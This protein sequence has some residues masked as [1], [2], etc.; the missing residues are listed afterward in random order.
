VKPERKISPYGSWLSP[1]SADLIAEDSLSLGQIVLDGRDVYWSEMR[2]AD[3]GRN[4]IMRWRQG[5]LEEILPAPF[6]AR[7]RVNEYGG[8]AFTV[9][10]RVVYFSHDEDQHLYR[11]R[12]GHPPHPLTSE[13]GRRYADGAFDHRFK[14]IICV[15][16]D[17]R[18]TGEPVTTIVEVDGSGMGKARVLVS[19]HDFYAAPKISTD[20]LRM[21]WLAWNHP[22]MPWDG[23]ELWLAD[24]A[25]DGSLINRRLVAGGREESIFQPAFSPG[26]KLY[27]VS[28][29]SHW[30]NLYRV[31]EEGIEAMSP[32]DAEFGLPQWVFGM[33]TYAIESESR[34]V[35]SFNR[36]GAWQLATLDLETHQLNFIETPFTDIHGLVVGH[37]QAVFVAASPTLLPAVVRMDLATSRCE[38]LRTSS[39][40][41]IKSGYLSIP[42]SLSFPT[43]NGLKTYAFYYPPEN[44]DFQA[45]T[46]GKPPLLVMGHGGPTS[47][48]S[49][50][51]S[52]KIQYWTSRG[53]AVLDVN[54]RGSTGYGRD[55]RNQLDGLWG[56]A[57]VEDCVAGARHL[58]K[59]GLVDEKRLGIRGG[60]AG[61]YTTLCALASHACFRAAA[62]YYGVS[63]LEALARDTH[64]FESHYLNRLIGPY[65]A[66]RDLYQKRS[67]VNHANHMSCPVIFFQGLEDKVVPPDQT[68]KMVNDL[69][70]RGIPLA[71]VAFAGESHG[72]RR[73]ENIKRSL[74]SELYFYAR[75]FGFTP[76]D[77][78]T[79]VAI[80]N[81]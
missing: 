30:W 31:H 16:E 3:G 40:T 6:N 27:F 35:C 22:D 46:G 42:R 71:Y 79:P 70:R 32:M 54:Y 51:L 53:F 52:F 48:A 21:A 38:I 74:E 64:K 72:F 26:G 50:S 36:E 58:I 59:L 61:G 14:R 73:A 76:A 23:S 4:V 57:D 78:L 47:A 45:P 44:R 17:H 29:R 19:G 75:V 10:E 65:P 7:T 33:A 77:S 8:G 56:I 66:R 2:P 24:V 60:S 41:E 55:Y 68:E 49:N 67:P 1:I 62:V 25:G 5:G 20:G 18:V 15:S 9:A 69:R 80:E 43:A 11:L 13:V 39:T 28:D 12:P 81:L 63:D 34:M 37:G